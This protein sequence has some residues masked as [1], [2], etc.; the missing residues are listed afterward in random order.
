[1]LNE[2]IND[3]YQADGRE[4]FELTL[5]QKQ[6]RDRIAIK[7]QSGE[8]L[9]EDVNCPL[10][11]SQQ[12]KLLAAKDAYG[13]AVKTVVC[14]ACGIV[15]T[16]PRLAEES[17]PAFYAG[18]YR[19]LD[20]VLP[21]VE[22]YFQ[23]EREK[24]SRIYNMLHENGL[25]DR[26]RGKLVIEIGCGAGGVLSYFESNGFF[27][28]GCDFVPKH[29]EYGASK[30]NMELHL[31]DLELIKNIVT[32]RASEIGLIIYEQVFEHIPYPK[33]ELE[34]VH[35]LMSSSSLLYIG[36]PGFKNIDAQYNSDFIR[37]LQLPHLTHFDLDRLTA[38][39]NACGFTLLTGNELVQAVYEPSVGNRRFIRQDYR[40]VESFLSE[41][42]ERRKKKILFLW[43][44]QFTSS[45]K[46]FIKRQIETSKIPRPL[47]EGLINFMRKITR[48]RIW[49]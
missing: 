34:M 8:Y 30:Q 21:S 48:L 31:G 13:L 25:L 39:M 12:N 16:N 47:K 26:I 10:C 6:A 45:F 9:V 37:F 35:S 11:G 14:I 27:V 33:K 32:S 20:R 28:L 7:L 44:V 43:R 24:G 3:R 42:E 40:Q 4:V 41:M 22:D 19:D 36:V 1:M 17:L 46:R 15:Y 23:L 5:V 38:M 18:E 2:Q 29:L 49:R